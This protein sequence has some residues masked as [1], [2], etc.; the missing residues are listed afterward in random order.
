MNMRS[1][2]AASF[3]C[4]SFLPEFGL[5]SP[6]ANE[7]LRNT[8]KCLGTRNP[9]SITSN[10]KLGQVS[11]PVQSQGFPRPRGA[12]WHGTSRKAH[13][14]PRRLALQP[15]GPLTDPFLGHRNFHLPGWCEP[16]LL[17]DTWNM[18]QVQESLRSDPDLREHLCKDG[19]QESQDI[20]P[21]HAEP[22]LRL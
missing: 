13:D 18:E 3:P 17:P 16:R 20:S 6:S 2:K 21:Q 22:V 8:N 7:Q 15:N 11:A 4:P 14:V 9:G 12:W 1:V 19:K 5:T 10:V